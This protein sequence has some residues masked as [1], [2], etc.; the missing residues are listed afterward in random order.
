MP[1]GDYDFRPSDDQMSFKE[2]LLHMIANMMWLSSSYLGGNALEENIR[3]GSFSK[4]EV[5]GILRKAFGS[6]ADAVEKLKASQLDEEVDFFAGPMNKRQ[7]LTL[8]NDHLIHH[9]GQLVVYLRL[10]GIQPPRYRG[11]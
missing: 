9:R 8:M 10:N 1:D 7:I 6:S 11:W 3:E 5:L 2:Q 4:A